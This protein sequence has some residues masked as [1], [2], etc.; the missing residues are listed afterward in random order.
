MEELSKANEDESLK[1]RRMQKQIA[2]ECLKRFGILE[3]I[4]KEFEETGKLYYSERFNSV[5]DGILYWVSN[6]PEWEEQIKELEKEYGI[7]VYHAYLY[8]ASYG[9]VLDCLYVSSDP[10]CFDITLEDCKRGIARIYAINL[11]N[12]DFSEFGEGMYKPRNGGISKT[13]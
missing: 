3:N 2:C 13:A 8:Y 11:T 12:P 9:T 4:R 1:N 6:H 7:L 10:D 5:M